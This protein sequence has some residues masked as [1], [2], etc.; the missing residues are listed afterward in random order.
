MSVNKVILLGNVGGDPELRYPEKDRAIDY[1]SLA[2]KPIVGGKRQISDRAV[3]FRIAYLGISAHIAQKYDFVH[4]HQSA[5]I[6]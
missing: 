4:R 6:G 3:L 2:A 1:L 5:F